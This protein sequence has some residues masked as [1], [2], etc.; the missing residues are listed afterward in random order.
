MAL[1]ST[2]FKLDLNIA[3]LDRQYYADFPL[4]L[5]RH[6]S[7]T[8]ERMMLRV[9]AFALNASES[10]EFGRGISTDDEPDLWHKDLTGSIETWIELGTPDP[11]RLRKACS[12]ARGVVLYAYGDRAVPVWWQKHGEGLE[13]FKHLEVWQIADADARALAAMA[14]SGL[15]L[16]CT[17]SGGEAWLTGAAE[18]LTVRPLQLKACAQASSDRR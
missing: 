9:L 3:D 8:D 13:R 18:S 16:Q 2:I 6:P 7:E 10:L 17:L 5:A 12:R 15:A 11:D 1:K 4:T 14:R